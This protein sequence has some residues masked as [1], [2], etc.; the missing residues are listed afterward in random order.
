[1]GDGQDLEIYHTGND[2][3]IDNATGHLYIRQQ[4]N[5]EDI[6]IQCDNGS[7]GL[8][9]YI[10]CDGSTGSVSLGNYSSTKLVT[11]SD[12][13]EIEGHCYPESTNSYDLGASAKR[14][15]NV[16][17]NDLNLSNEG[18]TNEI[19][20]TWG[21]WTIQ[22]GEDDLFLLNRRNGK[23]YKFNLTEVN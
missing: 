11:K 19:D 13:V 7:G 16:Y 5:D 8:A 2:T 22:E 6:Y 23:K 1:M 10:H 12:G 17:T 4:T 21:V 15:R 18:S 3:Y 14:W 9:N 20:G